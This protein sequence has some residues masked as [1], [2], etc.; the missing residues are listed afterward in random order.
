MIGDRRMSSHLVRTGL[1][2]L[3]LAF[4]TGPARAEPPIFAAPEAALEALR[5]ALLADD[6]KAVVALFGPEHEAEL[7]GAD[8]A[9]ARQSLDAASDAAAQGMGLERGDDDDHRV[10]V[11]G[12]RDWPFPIPLVRTDQGWRFDIEAGLEEIIDRR[13]GDNELT[14]I[15]NVRAFGDAQLTYAANDHDAD[16]VLEYAQKLVSTESQRDGTFGTTR[17]ATIRAHWDRWPLPR[18][19]TP[20]TRKPRTPST[21]TTTGSSPPRA[22][23]FPVAPT[24]MSSTAT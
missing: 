2:A 1:A 10:I 9:A 4:A 12:T 20:G 24:T 14:A 5:A 8:P 3:T 6:A 7:I 13:I 16:Q 18:P 17:P 22:P 15:A 11:L 19:T 23:T 21:A